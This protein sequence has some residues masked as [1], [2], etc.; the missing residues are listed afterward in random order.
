MFLTV[1]DPRSSKKI[2]SF[3]LTW[4]WT[5]SDRRTSPGSHIA[6]SLEAMF[7]PSP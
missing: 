3:R 7:T 4:S 1:Q 6:C 5:L 2:L